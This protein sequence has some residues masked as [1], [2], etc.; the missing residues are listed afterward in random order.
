MNVLSICIKNNKCYFI[1]FFLTCDGIC[2][3]IVNVNA[4]NKRAY[5]SEYVR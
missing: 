5:G 4:R 2:T 3:I 1:I